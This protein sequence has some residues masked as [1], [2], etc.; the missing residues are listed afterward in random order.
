MDCCYGD[1]AIIF[2][3]VGTLM[4]ALSVV[5]NIASKAKSRSLLLIVR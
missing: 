5:G 1:T 3:I 2:I 4:V